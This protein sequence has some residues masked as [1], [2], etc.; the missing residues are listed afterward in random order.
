[1]NIRKI[2]GKCAL[3]REMIKKEEILKIY[4]ELATHC[5]ELTI[6]SPSPFFYLQCSKNCTISLLYSIPTT[7]SSERIRSWNYVDLRFFF[8]LLFLFFFHLKKVLKNCFLSEREWGEKKMR[9]WNTEGNFIKFLL[10][11]SQT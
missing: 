11:F 6:I 5:G 9:C 7:K 3:K 2:P 1:M 8:H 10:F 4:N